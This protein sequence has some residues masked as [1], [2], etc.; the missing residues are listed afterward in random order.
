MIHSSTY[1]FFLVYFFSRAL[2][3]SY[4]NKACFLVQKLYCTLDIQLQTK[5]YSALKL[6]GNE[7]IEIIIKNMGGHE[8]AGRGTKSASD[9][10]LLYQVSAILNTH[11]RRE[12]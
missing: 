11:R 4:D 8:S 12:L 6:H 7:V 10:K 5:T 1:A 2:G 3:V 9:N